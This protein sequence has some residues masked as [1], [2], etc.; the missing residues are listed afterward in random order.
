MRQYLRSDLGVRL[1]DGREHKASVVRLWRGGG[2]AGE[3]AARI[4]FPT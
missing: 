4:N 3:G 1:L 2:A